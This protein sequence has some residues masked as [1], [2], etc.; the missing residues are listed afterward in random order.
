M[1]TAPF[2]YFSF[3]SLFIP[4]A[5][6]LLLACRPIVLYTD[7][8][9]VFGPRRV[10]GRL[11]VKKSFTSQKLLADDNLLM[12]S[13]QQGPFCCGVAHKYYVDRWRSWSWGTSWGQN[14]L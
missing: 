1:M 14:A 13:T 11:I 7:A 5:Q 9:P 2:F 3:P 12:V 6:R 10:S 8:V 4:L